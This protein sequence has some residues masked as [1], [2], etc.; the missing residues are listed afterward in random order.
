[1]GSSL[2]AE[3][4]SSPLVKIGSPAPADDL[5]LVAALEIVDRPIARVGRL[6]DLLTEDVPAYVETPQGKGLYFF[7]G[8]RFSLDIPVDESVLFDRGWKVRAGHRPMKLVIV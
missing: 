4:I 2:R 1:M 6:V 3:R 5:L 8:K 7:D